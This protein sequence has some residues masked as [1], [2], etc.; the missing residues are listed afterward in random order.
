MKFTS[1]EIEGVYG[2]TE[3]PYLDSR[4]S[5]TRVWDSNS[6]LGDFDLIQSSIVTNPDMATLRGIHFQSEP[7]SENKVVECINGRVFDVVVDIRKNSP[8]YGKHLEVLLGP[9]EAYLGLFIPAGCAHGY[10]TLEPESTLLYFMDKEYSPKHASGIL[11][12]DTALS[13]GWPQTPNKISER[14]LN[15]PGFKF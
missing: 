14:D 7:F 2:I 8:S 1:L 13:I 9:F 5:L 3:V 12:N 10:L 6:I 11:W 4:G 15:W